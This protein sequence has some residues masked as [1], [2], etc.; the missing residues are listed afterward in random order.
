MV[1]IATVGFQCGFDVAAP[2][3]GSLGRHP[4]PTP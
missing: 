4:I 1:G 3:A 2:I